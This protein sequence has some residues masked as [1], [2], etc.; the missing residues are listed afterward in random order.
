MIMMGFGEETIMP[1]RYTGM[2]RF[3]CQCQPL[4]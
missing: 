1:E 3:H 4:A 2:D